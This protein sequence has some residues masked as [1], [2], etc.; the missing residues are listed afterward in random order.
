MTRL[1]LTALAATVAFTPLAQAQ[2]YRHD[3][4]RVERHYSQPKKQDAKRFDRGPTAGRHGPQKPRWTRGH[5]VPNWQ[6]Q[7]VVRDWHRPGLRKP[8]RNQQW[9][10]VGN[11]YLLISALSGL[12]AGIIATR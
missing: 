1:I 11:D 8:G 12:I 10:R 4:R 9:V 5:R 7:Q 3:D 2:S 6:R